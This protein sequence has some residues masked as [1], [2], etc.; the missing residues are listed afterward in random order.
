MFRSARL[1]LTAWYLI[2]IMLISVSFSAAMYRI[3]GSELDRIARAQQFRI[4]RGLPS[5]P[6]NGNSFDGNNDLRRSLL[7]DPDLLTEIKNRLI[8]ILA[9]INFAILGTSAVAGYFLAGRTLKP[10]Q[11]M[12]DEQNRFITDSSHELRTP[13]TSLKSE[14]EV[15]LRDRKLTLE[16]A[17]KILFSNLEEVNNLQVLS[18]SL[19]RLTQYQK[20]QSGMSVENLSLKTVMCFS[21]KKVAGLARSKKIGI[22]NQITDEHITANRQMITELFV[23]FLDNAIKY[24]HEN[25]QVVLTSDRNDGYVTVQ[26]KD[27]GIGIEK[28]NIP[29]LFDRFYRSDKSRNKFDAPGYGL[30]LAI[31]KQIMDRHGGTIHVESE[32]N[33]GTTFSLQLPVD[34][35]L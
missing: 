2:I 13:L 26:I 16:Q 23:I 7:L 8:A 3:I 17:K 5:F 29:H 18:D 27:R 15:S 12:M 9:L 14:I 25:T 35:K 31:A 28:E 32:P 4:E 21:V 10:I 22:V 1:K 30:G 6:R 34:Y 19:I 24:S 33:R 20:S 11:E